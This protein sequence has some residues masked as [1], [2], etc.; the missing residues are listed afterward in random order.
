M[1]D[2]WC[3]LF[4]CMLHKQEKEGIIL[5]MQKRGFTTHVHTLEMLSNIVDMQNFNIDCDAVSSVR[6]NRYFTKWKC[7]PDKLDTQES[8]NVEET[9][10]K[11]A[12]IVAETGFTTTTIDR[13]D[14]AIDTRYVPYK[15]LVDINTLL[16][17][18]IGYQNNFKNRQRSFDYVTTDEKTVRAQDKLSA[19]S[20]R[21]QIEYY[22]K[23]LQ[24]KQTD[25]NGRFEFRIKGLSNQA[26]AEDEK[27]SYCIDTIIDLMENVLKG[28]LFSR[29]T[30]YLNSYLLKIWE[31][32]NRAEL[33]DFITEYK[34]FFLTKYQLTRFIKATGKN[35][36]TAET[37]A[38][39][40]RKKVTTYT[41]KQLKGYIGILKKSLLLYKTGLKITMQNIKPPFNISA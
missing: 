17:G 39:H 19:S 20:W 40:Y 32:E 18:L 3:R 8:T 24:K 6:A 1:G 26:I 35:S 30:D 28:K 5:F 41:Q 14:I 15:R 22:N 7:N 12:Q 21:Y 36:G 27:I 16:I 31:E 9:N 11:I 10:A 2:C 13:V 4:G 38:H 23:P 34:K 33:S 37:L 29:Y 25:I